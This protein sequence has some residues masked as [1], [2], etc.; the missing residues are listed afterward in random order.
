MVFQGISKGLLNL[1]AP[2]PFIPLLEDQEE[3]KK[4]YPYWR[5][6]I[7]YSMF[8]GY[9]F[10]YFSRKSLVFAMPNL[11]ADLGFTKTELG[12]LGSTL[13]IS[14]GFSKFVNGIFADKSNPRYFMATG[15]IVTGL[16]N[17][18]FGASSTIFY[19]TLFWGLNGWFQGFGWPPAARL[20]THW[21]SQSERGRWWALWSTSHNVGGAIIPILGAAAAQ[22]FGWR[23]ALYIPG[24]LCILMGLFLLERL[25]DTPQSL[26]LP[27]IETYR[28]DLPSGS[29]AEYEEKELSTKQ[30][31]F[32]YVLANRWIWI[33]AFAYFF[34]YIIRTAINDWTA[35]YLVE[36][37]GYSQ[38]AAG[39]AVFWFEVGGFFGMLVAGWMSDRFFDGKRG[40]TLFIYGVGMLAST[41]FFW[42]TPAGY[43]LLDSFL[44]CLIGFMVFGPQMLIGLAAAEL[45]HKK[46]AATATGFTGWFAYLGAAVAGYPLG[47]IAE[48]YGWQGYFWTLTICAVIAL[49]LFI[50]LC[51]NP[52]RKETEAENFEQAA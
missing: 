12:F 38:L 2:A 10:Y 40:Q 33:L 39:G 46:A 28:N 1:F 6:R 17:I 7:F 47:R 13:S 16:L 22:Y 26:G 45:S 35:L 29:S 31:L 14:Y 8:I 36:M 27:A 48:E 9:A 42:M 30:I 37:K 20:L 41:I 43:W 23:Y 15:L 34:V 49:L 21:Y 19:F 3:I 4:A 44:V 24:G 32:D 18:A 25:R 5:L 51:K 52:K 11:I 50:P